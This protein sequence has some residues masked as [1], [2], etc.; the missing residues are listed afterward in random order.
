MGITANPIQ[1][2]DAFFIALPVVS[3]SVFIPIQANM[4]TLNKIIIA[5]EAS[6]LRFCILMYNSIVSVWEDVFGLVRGEFFRIYITKRH[7]Y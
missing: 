6:F 3:Q 7:D 4:A 2:G 5:L 1:V